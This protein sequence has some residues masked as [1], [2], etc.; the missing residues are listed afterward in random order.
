MIIIDQIKQYFWFVFG[1][2]GVVF[3]WV[4]VWDGI[5][6]LPY[7]ENPLLSLF[8]GLFMFGMSKFV[9]RD[10]DPFG[11]ET[12]KEVS[13]VLRRV[14][15]HPQ[16]HEFHIKYNDH[17]KKAQVHMKAQ[18]IKNIEK[19]FVVFEE[20]NKEI[21]VP[22]NRISEIIHKGKTHWKR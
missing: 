16:K 13:K 5:G 19:G 9:F 6:Y 22:F 20:N 1:V 11:S 18:K 17:L 3:F 15:K 8:L 14:H 2:I 12:E 10:A 4:G 7:L 21:F